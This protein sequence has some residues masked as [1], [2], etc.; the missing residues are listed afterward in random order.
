MPPTP[1]PVIDGGGAG[2]NGGGGASLSI[3]GIDIG[4]GTGCS[5][6]LHVHV[7]GPAI[8][9]NIHVWNAY[10]DANGNVYPSETFASG[11]S[12]HSVTLGGQSE[13][14]KVHEVWIT[15]GV[16]TSNRL[17]GLVCNNWGQ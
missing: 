6:T 17:T 10:Y 1:T 4:S 15:S 16:G 9:G 5:A 7:D 12:N 3:T 11:D 2:G 8:S 14:H 13:D